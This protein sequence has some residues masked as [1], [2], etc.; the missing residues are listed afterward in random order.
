MIITVI[1]STKEVIYSAM[2]RDLQ[3][4][5][6]RIHDR[7]KMECCDFDQLS[8][9]SSLWWGA[10]FKSGLEGDCEWEWEIFSVTS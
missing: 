1:F 8:V 10:R 6:F 5:P 7:G 4:F 3:D 2:Q 9:L